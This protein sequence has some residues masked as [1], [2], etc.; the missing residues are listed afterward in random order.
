[1][2]QRTAELASG[3]F[4]LIF[5]AV[6]YFYLTPNFIADPMRD[7][8]RQKIPWALLPEMLPQLTIGAFSVTS[9]VL[10]VQAYRSK[11]GSLLD[12]E[13]GST[14]KVL[15]IVALTLIYLY[16]LPLLGF[17]L[18]T[19]VFMALLI[20]MFGIRNWF[21][22]AAI[23]IIMPVVLDYSFYQMFKLILPEGKLWS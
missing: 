23:S 20:A 2:N 8:D 11:S 9:L 14:L 15:V 12:L 10:T 4:F 5:S 16:L 6:Y 3:I 1:M 18:T 17:L 19:P 13:L 7:S 22:I 21:L